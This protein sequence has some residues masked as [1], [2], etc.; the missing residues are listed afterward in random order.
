MGYSVSFGSSVSVSPPA[1]PSQ[2][3]MAC[4]ENR[5]RPRAGVATPRWRFGHAEVLIMEIVNC[6]VKV[7]NEATAALRRCWVG[8]RDDPTRAAGGGI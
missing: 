4:T 5:A 2:R 6:R 8:P 1:R 7:K 3:A